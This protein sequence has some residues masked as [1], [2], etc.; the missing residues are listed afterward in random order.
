MSFKNR[1]QR[2]KYWALRSSRIMYDFKFDPIKAYL[3]SSE[4]MIHQQEIELTKRYNKWN[5]EN[6]GN[7]D[8]PD[9]F[10]VYEMEILNSSEFPNILNQSVYLTIYSTFENEF[11]KICEWCKRVDHLKIGPRDI[12]DQSYI[13]QCRK[14]ITKVLDVNLD[15]LNQKWTEI[16]KYQFIRNAIAHNSGMIKKPDHDILTFIESSN[17]IMFDS[18]NSKIKM[19]SIEF[20]KVFIDKLIDF[21]CEII[22]RIIEEKDRM[23][24]LQG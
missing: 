9:A 4:E 7:P 21:L 6:S 10:D 18:E 13:G 24:M 1:F 16:K 12:K 14:F 19:E 5:K 8:I 3:E 15:N 2:S 22:E 11:F 17:G 23:E 20:L